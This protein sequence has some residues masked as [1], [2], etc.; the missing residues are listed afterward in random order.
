MAMGTRRLIHVGAFNLSLI[1]RSMLGAGKPRELR[2][3]LASLLQQPF[4]L[5]GR[6]WTPTV[7]TN[8]VFSSLALRSQ[9]NRRYLRYRLRHSKESASATGC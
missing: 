3:R 5:L 1:L 6:L 9:R 4:F 2:N 7:R 8:S